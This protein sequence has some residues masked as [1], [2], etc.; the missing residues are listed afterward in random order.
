MVQYVITPWRDRREL[1]AVRAQFYP[2]ISSTSN[3]SYHRSPSISSLSEQ[4]LQDQHDAVSRVHMWTLRGG[5]PHLVESTALLTAAMLNE[6]EGE[7]KGHGTRD[8]TLRLAYSTAFSR[9]V[10]SVFLFGVP[11]FL[12]HLPFS[13]C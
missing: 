9:L 4:Q 2:T 6:V 7:L 12:S 10:L 13:S 11:I 3:S 8:F 5:C 1:L